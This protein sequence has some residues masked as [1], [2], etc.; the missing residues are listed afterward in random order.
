MT[1][2]RCAASELQPCRHS[3]RSRCRISWGCKTPASKSP[4]RTRQQP[5]L[6]SSLQPAYTKPSIARAFS[7]VN[8]RTTITR[9][10]LRRCQQVRQSWKNWFTFTDVTR[11]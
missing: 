1:W 5:G 10:S 11:S 6:R 8:Q 7:W 9:F 2:I 4:R 3:R